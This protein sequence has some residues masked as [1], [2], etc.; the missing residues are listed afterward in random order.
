MAR[1]S[2]VSIVCSQLV[3]ALRL[4]EPNYIAG[5]RV[6]IP[7]RTVDVCLP[8]QVWSFSVYQKLLSSAVGDR[9]AQ[10]LVECRSSCVPQVARGGR[11]GAR[12]AAGGHQIALTVT[13]LV[14]GDSG[15][16]SC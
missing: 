15:C 12:D 2:S 4:R 14:P 5:W 9:E 7:K 8:P 10:G 1:A 3:D 6:A 13:V 16:S 11:G